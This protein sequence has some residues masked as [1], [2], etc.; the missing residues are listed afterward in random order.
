MGVGAFNH[1]VSMEF[2]AVIGPLIY[3]YTLCSLFEANVLVVRLKATKTLSRLL[4]CVCLWSFIYYFFDKK[5]KKIQYI[6]SLYFVLLGQKLTNY[7]LILLTDLDCQPTDYGLVFMKTMMK[8]LKSGMMRSAQQKLIISY[9]L[10][11]MFDYLLFSFHY[12][13]TYIFLW[14]TYTLPCTSLCV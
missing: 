3:I 5:K 2:C 8:L 13:C 14:Y 11:C 9:R 1:R 4:A 10:I 6:F 12:L 7:M